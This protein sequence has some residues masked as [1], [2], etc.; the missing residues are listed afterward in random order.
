MR[1]ILYLEYGDHQ[2]R[3]ELKALPK[4]YEKVLGKTISDN[5]KKSYKWFY[6][7]FKYK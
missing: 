7:Y 6:D 2:L 1:M 5:I 4:D 3:G